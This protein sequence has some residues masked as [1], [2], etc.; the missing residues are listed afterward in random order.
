VVVEQAVMLVRVLLVRQT[1]EAGV[2]QVM[3][4]WLAHQAVAV[5]SSFATPAQFNI[6]LVAQ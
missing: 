6:S 2:V 5:L 4:L 3:A 1:Q